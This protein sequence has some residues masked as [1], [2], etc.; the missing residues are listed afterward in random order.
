[1]S[2]GLPK[3]FAGGCFGG[4][5]RGAWSFVASAVLGG[6]AALT[7]GDGETGPAW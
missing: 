1:M 4:E 6:A 2:R 3:F 7:V 5:T